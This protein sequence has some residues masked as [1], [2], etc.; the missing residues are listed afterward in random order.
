MIKNITNR[1]ATLPEADGSID[2]LIR[3]VALSGD[4]LGDRVIR[5]LNALA[6]AQKAEVQIKPDGTGLVWRAR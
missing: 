1:L 5:R 4:D 3:M 2:A 6:D